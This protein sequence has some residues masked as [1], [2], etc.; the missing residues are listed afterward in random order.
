M[1]KLLVVLP[2][3]ISACTTVGDYQDKCEQ[4]YSKLS[5][6]ATCLDKDVKSDFR[7]SHGATPKLYV[8]AAKM[9][10]EEVDSG[11]IS[12][13]QARYQLQSLYVSL[14]DKQGSDIN[15]KLSNI[16][17]NSTSPEQTYTSY[18]KNVPVKNPVTTTCNAY[19]SGIGRTVTCNSQQLASWGY[20][21]PD[22]QPIIPTRAI[23]RLSASG[24]EL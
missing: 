24:K 3:F 4:R 13:A 9:L 16:N 15:Q 7:M 17:N 22:N 20:D 5:D 18:I 1:K 21:K 23:V 19:G 6:V 2:L 8:Q 14:K 12:D 10:G 11:K